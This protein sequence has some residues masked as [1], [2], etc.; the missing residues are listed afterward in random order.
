MKTARQ[1]RQDAGELWR[2]CMSDGMLDE[3]RARLVVDRILQSRRAGAAAVVK[4]FF[5]LLRLHQAEHT[6][7]V[8]SAT[9]LDAAVRAE[10]ETGLA[11]LSTRGVRTTYVVDPALIGGVRV[12]VGSDVYDGSIRAG[13]AALEAR[14]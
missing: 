14:F 5:R 4:Q 12:Q 13:L 1:A 2:V 10:L 7:T 9:P 3:A 6:A 11:R 8:A